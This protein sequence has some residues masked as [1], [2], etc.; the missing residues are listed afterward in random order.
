MVNHNGRMPRLG[1]HM[2]IAGGLPRAVERAALHGCEALQIF[3]KSAGRGGPGPCPPTRCARSAGTRRNRHR[4]RGRARQ[5]SDQPRGARWVPAGAVRGRAG[6]GARTRR[7]LGL[8]GV[9]LHPG[10]STVGDEAGGLQRIAHALVAVLRARPRGG[11]GSCWSPTGRGAFLAIP[12]SNWRASHRAAGRRNSPRVGVWLTR[13]TSSPPS[14]TSSA[15][16]VT[17]T[18]STC[19]TARSV[20]SAPRVS[21]ER[22]QGAARHARIDRHEH[23]GKGQLRLGPFRR[24]LNDRRFAGL[25]MLLSRRPRHDASRAPRSRSTRSTWRTYGPCAI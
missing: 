9:V 5:L 18:Y 11:R 1:A 15:R 12:S 24:L 17:R 16:R 2:S 10:A 25:P 20:R 22:L 6:R 23:I 7:S 3:T 21:L 19:S 14:T 8:A 13:A 4:A